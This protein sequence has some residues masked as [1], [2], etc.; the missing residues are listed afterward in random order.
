MLYY[1][2]VDISEGIDLAKNN[3]SEK[4][5]ICHHWFLIA[6][7]SFKILYAKVVMICQC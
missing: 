2:R 3:Y 1:D 7:S 4:F 5:I 6:D